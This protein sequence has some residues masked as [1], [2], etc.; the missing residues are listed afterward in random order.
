MNTTQ[1]ITV[2]KNKHVT[3][4]DNAHITHKKITFIIQENGSL[5]YTFT[6]LDQTTPHITREITTQL[7]GKNASVKIK[8]LFHGKK[9]S[10]LTFNTIQHHQ[11][12]HTVS[13]VSVRGV[14]DDQ[15]KLLNKSTIRV[16]KD[17]C[18]TIAQQMNK[19]LLLSKNARAVSIPILEV[20]AHDVSCS[21]GAAMS[22]L[23]K[24]HLFYLQSK[25]FDLSQTRTLL[26]NAFLSE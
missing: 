26:I 11:A 7:V 17:A 13:D 14:L 10:V 6:A 16:E 15:S 25:G 19:N 23:D 4:Q 24:N 8:N 1:I 3:L 18:K 2:P 20:L 5:E 9:D 21:H 12:P 22:N